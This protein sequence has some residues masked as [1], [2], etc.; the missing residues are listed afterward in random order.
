MMCDN[1]SQFE[2]NEEVDQE[3][4]GDIIRP[5]LKSEVFYH[6]LNPD[7]SNSSGQKG[8]KMCIITPEKE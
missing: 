5:N 6:Q 1:Q 3:F 7:P 8:P 2:Q 4:D